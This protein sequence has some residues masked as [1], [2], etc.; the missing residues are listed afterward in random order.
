MNYSN[1]FVDKMN[2]NRNKNL[3][4][5]SVYTKLYLHQIINNS[6]S[7]ENIFHQKFFKLQNKKLIPI[8]QVQF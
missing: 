3:F 6:R 1:S 7:L 8:F 5:V 2:K 4:Q